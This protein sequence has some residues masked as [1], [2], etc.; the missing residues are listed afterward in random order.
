[1]L[2][3]RFKYA[4]RQIITGLYLALAAIS[5]NADSFDDLKN[6]SIGQTVYFKGI[7]IGKIITKVQHPKYQ[8]H[9]RMEILVLGQL[10]K[11]MCQAR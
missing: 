1:M 11:V 10:R 9:T 5:A 6:A 8:T 4:K 7:V 3:N 2:K